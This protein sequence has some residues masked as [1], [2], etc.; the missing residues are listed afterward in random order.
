M[1]VSPGQRGVIVALVFAVAPAT[2]AAV[3]GAEVE[4]LDARAPWRVFA[5]IAPP[6]VGTAARCEPRGEDGEL[7]PSP[8]PPVDWT[9]SDFDDGVWGRYHDELGKIL[10]GYGYW[11]SPELALLCL[12]TRFDVVDPAAVTRLDFTLAYRGGAV[13]Y[14]NGREVAR[15]HLPVGPRPLVGGPPRPLVGGPPR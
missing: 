5:T 7:L 14:V 12:R 13:V 11:Q 15:G 6:M 1:I 4:V 2:V 8:F 9:D 3:R 10:G